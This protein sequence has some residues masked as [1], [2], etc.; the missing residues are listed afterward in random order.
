MSANVE[1]LDWLLKYAE[2]RGFDYIEARHHALKIQDFNI[3][4]GLTTS[5]NQSES[6]GFS[7]RV[8]KDNIIYFSLLR[9][10]KR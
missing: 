10:K 1:D 8:V 9:V 5:V 6:A 4:N 7:L 3:L 2:K